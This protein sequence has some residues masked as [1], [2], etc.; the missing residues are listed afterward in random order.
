MEDFLERIVKARMEIRERHGERLK[1][2]LNLKDENAGAESQE[3]IDKTVIDYEGA[4]VALAEAQMNLWLHQNNQ[5]M[6]YSGKE[7]S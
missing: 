3:D 1:R 6:M 5:G 2:R 4:E 7:S